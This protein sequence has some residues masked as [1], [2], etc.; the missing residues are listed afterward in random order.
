MRPIQEMPSQLGK[1]GKPVRIT[2]FH[3][4]DM[5]GHLEAIARLSTHA[6]KLREAAQAEGR[7]VFFWD[8]GDAA[9][10]R[11]QIC[12]ATK[13]SAFPPILNSMG[14]GLQTMGN[15]ISL[16]YGPQAM[17]DVAA[18]S[19]FP[20]LAANCRDGDGPLVEGLN[21]LAWIPL[22][23]EMSIGVIG[24][25]APW[26][27]FYELFGLS[28]PD[29]RQVARRLVA[30]LKDDGASVVVVLS[31]LGLEDDR[32][33]AD[34]VDGIDLIIGAHSH[35]RLARG[36]VRSGVLIA[37]A[38][39]YARAIGRVD[40]ALDP[41]TGRMISCSAS[42]ID[43]PD[44]T[45]PDQAVLMAISAAEQ[46]VEEIMAQAIGDIAGPLDLDYFQECG[47]GN[48]AADALRDRMAAE[49]A[50]VSSGQFHRALAAGTLT[51]GQLD[52]ACF[53]TA[54]PWLSEVRGEQLLEAL[55]R[56]LNPAITQV[57]H[58]GYRGAPVGFPQISGLLVEYDSSATVRPRVRR[59]V[60][61]G[62]LIEP[63]RL[64]RLAHT[65][66]ETMPEVGYLVLED[67]QTLEHEVPT[68]LREVIAEYVRQHS[69]VP[70][71]QRG[72]WLP[73]SSP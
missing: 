59:V 22:A 41:Q 65:D 50:M 15:A 16:T 66:A 70:E 1:P 51:L 60:V 32:R 49:V 4:N 55:E 52:A 19:E 24:L 12:S 69:P 28:F 63:D 23:G 61:Q 45:P 43:V 47:L 37:Q 56:G 71:P 46:E 73:T 58:P 34:E 48:L 31:H 40:L 26:G 8:A 36:E 6:R 64:Y 33:L 17:A 5:H 3:T 42:V 39:E 14:Y 9:D 2:I 7:E 18:R 62:Q 25:T 11:I 20:I 21:E 29:F 44:A 10:R 57:K 35:D 67:G 30:Q 53:S 27:S 68:I 13:G 38:G 54:N 72:R